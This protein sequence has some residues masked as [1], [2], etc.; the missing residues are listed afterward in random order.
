MDLSTPLEVGA[1]EAMAFGRGLGLDTSSLKTLANTFG[2]S[3]NVNLLA[4]QFSAFMAP[5]SNF[6]N[7]Q[8]QR[9]SSWILP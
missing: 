4:G 5:V 7:E 3:S 1:T 8:K 6:F 9:K 2:G